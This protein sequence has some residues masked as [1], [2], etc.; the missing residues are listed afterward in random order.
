MYIHT[1]LPYPKHKTSGGENVYSLHNRPMDHNLVTHKTL[2]DPLIQRIYVYNRMPEAK[3][4][5]I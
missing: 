2:H 5:Q 3:M 4:T 1:N